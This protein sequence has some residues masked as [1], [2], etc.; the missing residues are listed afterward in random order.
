VDGSHAW[1]PFCFPALEATL[2]QMMLMVVVYQIRAVL[3]TVAALRMW[4][5]LSPCGMGRWKV[6][7]IPRMARIRIDIGQECT[8]RSIVNLACVC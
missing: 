1:K 8:L 6:Q 3:P 2:H 4:S 7:E 5:F